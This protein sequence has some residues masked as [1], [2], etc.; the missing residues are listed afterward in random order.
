MR[1]Y[2]LGETCA[3][4][5]INEVTLRRWMRRASIS[6]HAD[7]SDHRRRYLTEAELVRLSQLHQRVLLV[8]S[9]E[10]SSSLLLAQLRQEIALLAERIERL[11]TM[12]CR[13]A[14]GPNKDA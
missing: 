11:E 5:A 8:P 2:S 4:F 12:P 9:Q 6:P 10:E 3:L 14:A 7:P 13:C 1:L